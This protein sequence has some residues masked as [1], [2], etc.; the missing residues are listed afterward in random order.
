VVGPVSDMVSGKLD[1]TILVLELITLFC[2]LVLLAG[3]VG[4]NKSEAKSVDFTASSLPSTRTGGWKFSV[5]LSPN[6]RLHKFFQSVVEGSI[7]GEIAFG[8]ILIFANRKRASAD[9]I[10]IRGLELKIEELRRSNLKLEERLSPRGLSPS[11]ISA[12]HDFALR[13]GEHDMDVVVVGSASE[14][15]EYADLITYPFR[16]ARWSVRFWSAPPRVSERGIS[17]FFFGG[18]NPEIAQTASDLGAAFSFAGIP[19]KAA[20]P[21]MEMG[22]P[23]MLMGPTPSH[24]K[25]APIRMYVGEK[26]NEDGAS[27]SPASP[28]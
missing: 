15:K 9:K 10:Q 12:L 17:L 14:T 21:F 11:Q 26:Q 24:M 18:A 28:Q 5:N 7:G 4:E 19:C 2:A 27:D 3:I 25:I 22:A 16:F 1:R 13:L 23:G 20:A 8:L 6:G